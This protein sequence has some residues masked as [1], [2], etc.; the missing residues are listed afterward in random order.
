VQAAPV[1]T[2]AVT[3][4]LAV[5]ALPGVADARAARVFASALVADFTLTVPALV[6]LLWVRA[7][8]IRV[9][10][11]V[12]VFVAGCAAAHLTIPSQ[13][14]VALQFAHVLAVSIELC[15]LGYLVIVARR[16]IGERLAGEGDFL[17]RLRT[18]ARL[19]LGSRIAADILTTEVSVIYYACRLRRASPPAESYTVHRE[20]GYAGIVFALLMV[21][22]IESVGM[23]MLVSR[24]SG[25]FAWI[26]SALSGYA[27]VWLIG[28]LRAMGARP[29]RLTVTHLHLRVG[30]RWEADVPIQDIIAV[31]MAGRREKR[32]DRQSLVAPLLGQP[33]VQIRL[34][35]PTEVLGMYGM[36]RTVTRIWLTV[37]DGEA[38]CTSFRRYAAT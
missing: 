13:H 5:F 8:R 18:A 7:G 6:Y 36:H 35:V 17:T 32:Q 12:P 28:D 10:A 37:D 21:L 24:W 34:R 38:F 30:L 31:E 2:L 1:L 20:V 33:N 29:I 19:V 11:L 26:L 14:A 9:I 3:A 22:G 25:A 4:I 16:L 15:V 27:F 23:H